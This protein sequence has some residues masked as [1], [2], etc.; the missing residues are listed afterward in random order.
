NDDPVRDEKFGHLCAA[1]DVLQAI[2]L[3]EAEVVVDASSHVVAIEHHTIPTLVVQHLLERDGDG[4]LATTAESG[5]PDH[6]AELAKQRLLVRP[7]EQAVLDR[8]Q[9]TI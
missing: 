7:L 3:T 5:H 2:R 1:S 9:V 8:M 4:G 6:L